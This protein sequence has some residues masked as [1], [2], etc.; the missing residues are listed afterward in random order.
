MD[1]AR[2]LEADLRRTVGGQVRFDDGTRA[3]YSTD[4]SNHRQVPIG[5][6][7][8]RDASDVEAAVAA[9]RE[10]GA[11][12]LPRGGGTSLAG[13]CCNVAVVIDT[14]QHLRRIVEIDPDA[15]TARVEPGVVCDQLTAAARRHGLVFG[16]DPATHAQ[17]TV[18]GMIGNNSCGVRSVAIGKTVDNVVALD[19]LRYDGRRVRAERE[20]PAELER[21]AAEHADE[22]AK[23]FPDIPRRVSGYNLDALVAGDLAKSLVGTE[24]TCALTLEATVNLVEHPASIVLVVLA[25]PSIA[26]AGDDVPALLEYDPV[27]LEGIEDVLVAYHAAKGAQARGRALLPPGGGW[28]LA[29][30]AG[31]TQAEAIA[32]ARAAVGAREHVLVSEP[33]DMHAVRQVRETALGATARAPGRPDSHPGWEDAAVPREKVG[34]YLRRFGALCDEHGYHAAIY[35]HFGDGCLHTRIDFELRTPDGIARYR[36]FL[37]AAADMTVELGG[38]LSG[39]HGDGQTRGELLERMFGPRIVQAFR[40]FKAYWDPDGKMNPGKVVDARPL[41]ADIRLRGFPASEPP[42]AL[43]YDDDDGR[44][45][46][47]TLRCV[48]VG[49]CRRSDAGTMCPSYMATLDERHSTRG[50][51][52]LLHEMVRGETITDGWRSEAVAEALDLCLGCKACATECP[53]NVD[54]ATYKAEF[55][56]QHYKR[57]VRPRNHYALGLLPYALRTSP[58]LVNALSGSRI[59]RRAAGLSTRRAMPPVAPEPFRRWFARRPMA[60]IDRPPVVLWPDTFTD[61]FHPHAAQAAVDVLEGAGYRVEVPHRAFCCGLTMFAVGMLDGARRAMRGA[62]KTLSA[63]GDAPVV[64]L[65]PSCTAMFRHDARSLLGEA[66]EPAARVKTLAEFLSA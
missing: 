65:E 2:S 55:L 49:K 45:S 11:P 64:C 3:L 27:G 35:G 37:E 53:V 60:P 29:E 9:C 63:Y 44:L 48:G 41:D 59:A 62:L 39:E 26:A 7:V 1:I 33:S 38:S 51:A 31:S 24:G 50:R 40:A 18:G 15:R 5:V 58:G 57:R 20:V 23:R 12:V 52:R 21:L 16:P 28:L 47:A 56:A 10:H 4:A 19:V 36:S 8:P 32:N 42:T 30:F 43:R 17:A 34:E 46:R 6:V 54:M 66:A 22:I 14:S 61:R 25:Y 13:Q